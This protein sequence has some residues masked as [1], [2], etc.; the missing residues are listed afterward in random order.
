MYE[1][2][3]GLCTLCTRGCQGVWLL[4]GVRVLEG[5]GVSEG[6]RVSASEGVGLAF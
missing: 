3:C 1:A 6:V 4:G 2:V 5:V